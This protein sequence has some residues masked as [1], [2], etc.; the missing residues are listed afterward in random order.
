MRKVRGTGPK[1]SNVVASIEDLRKSGEGSDG[2]LALAKQL[3]RA[4]IK[5][6][7]EVK[8]IPDRLYR[9]DFFIK[10]SHGR[11]VVVEV[12]GSIFSAGRHTR[13][14]GWLQDAEKYN[15]LT[16]MGYYVYRFATQQIIDTKKGIMIPEAVDWLFNT[17]VLP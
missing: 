12:E 2:E 13:G 3:D 10:A 17:G 4:G 1:A 16:S 14:K 8:L 6:E 15:T 7:R 11:L 5:Y 9:V